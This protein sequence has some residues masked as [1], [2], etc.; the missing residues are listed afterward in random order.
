MSSHVRCAN[1]ES[2]D[3]RCVHKE[4]CDSS[5]H[6]SYVVHAGRRRAGDAGVGAMLAL[7]TSTLCVPGKRASQSCTAPLFTG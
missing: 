3:V 5:V 4:K 2:Q 6:I 1:A 7:T